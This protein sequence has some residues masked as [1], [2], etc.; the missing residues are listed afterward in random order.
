MTSYPT[1]LVDQVGKDVR[2]KFG[3][4]VFKR[5]R[6]I[7][8]YAGHTRFTHFCAVL[9]CILSSTGRYKLV[10][11]YPAGGHALLSATR[12]KSWRQGHLQS[13]DRELGNKP[14]AKFYTDVVND[15]HPKGVRLENERYA[16]KYNF[17]LCPNAPNG[18]ISRTLYY[19]IAEWCS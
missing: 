5:G 8:L 3:D 14:I 7:Q 1:W 11:S 2:V 15:L 19:E 6:I 17:V 13:N 4:S 10:T 18:Q 16:A 9:N 12:W